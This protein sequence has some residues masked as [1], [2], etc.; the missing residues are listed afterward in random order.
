MGI[1]LA[2]KNELQWVNEQ[3]QKIGFV[4]SNLERETIA[5]VT[6]KDKYAGVG[7]I[8]YLNGEEAEIGGIC[9]LDEFRGLSLANELVDYLVKEAK[10]SNLKEIYCLPF[11]ELKCFYGK[12]GF[13]EFDYEG[14]QINNHI[15]K[16]YQWCLD[17]YEKKVLLLKL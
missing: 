14:K 12:F 6:Y 13:E 11:E 10:K 8:V 9:I 3:Y 4:P 16:K 15:L 2:T 1:K 7:R 17:N 5:I